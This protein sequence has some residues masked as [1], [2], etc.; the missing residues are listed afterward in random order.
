MPNWTAKGTYIEACNCEAICPCIVL[1]PPTEGSCTA[2]VGW[3]V[4]EG[5]FDGTDIGGLNVALLVHTPGHMMDGNW[6]VALYTD[7]RA[8]ESQA[9]ALAGIFSGQAGGHLSALGPLI[10]EV[11]GVRP[12]KIA[13]DG[14]DKQFSL[15]VDGVGATD[16]AALE[17]QDGGLVQVTGPPLAISPGQPGT[18]A[19][20]GALKLDDHGISLNVSGKGGLFAP[21]A[22][23]A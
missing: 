12:A 16:I 5:S 15:S 18:V 8:S 14:G 9:Q 4:D 23:A 20:A 7:E 6:K 3:H 17:G 21:F 1:S 11:L 13:F 19:R 10:G 22:Y 2:L